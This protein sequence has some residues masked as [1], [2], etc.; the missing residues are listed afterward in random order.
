MPLQS[1]TVLHKRASTSSK[2]SQGDKIKIGLGLGIPLAFFVIAGF[3]AMIMVSMKKKK[4][5]RAA[6]VV[7]E[8]E[9]DSIDKGSSHRSHA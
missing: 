9:V 1:A 8:V 3:I 6:G 4:K 7:T 2:L 5:K